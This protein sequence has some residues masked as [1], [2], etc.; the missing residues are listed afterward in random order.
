MDSEQIPLISPHV[1]IKYKRRWYI[2]LL[3]SAVAV[4]QGKQEFCMITTTNHCLDTIWNTWGPIDHTAILLYG[5]NHEL[6]ALFANYGS[7]LY[8]IGFLPMVW[9]LGYS[10]RLAMLV[11]SGFMATGT[12]LRYFLE[13]DCSLNAEILKIILSWKFN[14]ADTWLCILV[15]RA[16]HHSSPSA[17]ISAPSSTASPTSWLAVPPSQSPAP[18]SA[19]GRG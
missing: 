16:T 10:L 6:V 15:I 3:F 19:L 12:I 7:I 11:T 17:V 9:L 14:V 2:L 1:C 18:G 8:I 4:L 5:W 13:K